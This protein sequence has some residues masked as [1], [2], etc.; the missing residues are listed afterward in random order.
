M[1]QEPPVLNHM[2]TARSCEHNPLGW[3]LFSALNPAE[4][5]HHVIPNNDLMQHELSENCSCEPVDDPTAVEDYVWHH[6]ALDGREDYESG[7]RRAH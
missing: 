5:D 3:L 4:H 2:L 6:R 7:K 1:A